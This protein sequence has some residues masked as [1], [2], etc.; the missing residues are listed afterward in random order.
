[1]NCCDYNCNDEKNCPVHVAKVGKKLHGP[2]LLPPSVWRHILRRV[3]YWFVL[4]ILGML[5]MAFL[6]AC[7]VYAN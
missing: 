2:E 3:A 6:A 5:W 7:A 1:M 4:A